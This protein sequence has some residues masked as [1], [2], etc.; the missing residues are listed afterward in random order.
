MKNKINTLRQEVVQ[1][2]LFSK[3]LL[4]QILFL[5]EVEVSPF[6][7]AKKILI[8][9]DAVEMGIAAIANQIGALP[10]QNQRFLMDYFDPIKNKKHK[11]RDMEGKEYC[12]QLNIVRGNL[13]HGMILPDP[14]QWVRVGNNIYSYLSDWCKEYL[15]IS[16]DDLDNSI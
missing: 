12:R 15:K 9:H 10:K 11:K 2:L 4:S 13:K 5:P 16:L 7:I 14:N 3:S 8:A 6:S 1:Q